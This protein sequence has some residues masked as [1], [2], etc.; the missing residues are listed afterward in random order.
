MEFLNYLL[1][2][3]ILNL[4]FD[5]K[6]IPHIF[7]TQANKPRGRL[8]RDDWR[9]GPKLEMLKWWL[10]LKDMVQCEGGLG[11]SHLW[12]IWIWQLRPIELNVYVHA[13]KGK[14]HVDHEPLLSHYTHLLVDCHWDARFDSWGSS[15]SFAMSQAF[16]WPVSSAPPDPWRLQPSIFSFFTSNKC[17]THQAAEWLAVRDLCLLTRE[18]PAASHLACLFL[19]G[20][21]CGT[22][23]RGPGI[24]SPRRFNKA[25]WLPLEGGTVYMSHCWSGANISEWSRIV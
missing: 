25:H 20:C 11:T 18:A 7:F 22:E 12:L 2:T 5:W 19:S 8:V 10:I 4:P 9:P 1:F 13:C 24:E 15:I 16:S 6:S 23:T 3:S 14:V 17:V 21:W